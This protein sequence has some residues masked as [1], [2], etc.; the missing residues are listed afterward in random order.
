M[1]S[2]H[3]TAFYFLIIALLLSSPVF[4]HTINYALE[5]APRGLVVSYYLELGFKH[6]I[7]SGLDHILF[8]S[9]L[10]LLNTRIKTI[11]WQATAFTVAHSVTL[12][13]SMKNII[14]VPSAITEPIIALS[15]V[16]VASENILFSQLKP[17]RVLIVFIFGLIHGMGFAS[18]LNQIGLPPNKF[19]TCILAFN[20]GVELGQMSV[21]VLIFS[22]IVAAWGKRSWYRMRVV[23][24]LS[25]S[26]AGIACYWT[27]ERL[28]FT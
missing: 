23:Y 16:F 22:S 2:K 1:Y 18:S 15:I 27:V 10:C 12:A 19:Y 17:W 11:L 14:V 8:V 3:R 20:G 7:P 4:A 13:L 5:K 21:I 26:I 28:F 25:I 24:P 6:I 9:G